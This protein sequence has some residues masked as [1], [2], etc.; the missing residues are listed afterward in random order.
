[1][2][3]TQASILVLEKAVNGKAEALQSSEKW[4]NTKTEKNVD[5]TV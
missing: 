2:N 1:M 4:L 5:C 3:M